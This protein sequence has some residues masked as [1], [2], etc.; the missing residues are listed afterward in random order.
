MKRFILAV[1]LCS[2][3]QLLPAQDTEKHYAAGVDMAV[4]V[5]TATGDL[6]GGLGHPEQKLL[7]RGGY[8]LLGIR[9]AFIF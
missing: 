4:P 3:V 1:V 7:Q 6:Q 5:Y 2:L 9:T 8:S